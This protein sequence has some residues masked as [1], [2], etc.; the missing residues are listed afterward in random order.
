MTYQPV[1]RE[2]DIPV[3]PEFHVFHQKFKDA[4]SFFGTV[5]VKFQRIVH[6]EMRKG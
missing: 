6:I 4:R 2:D 3:H 1:E 5:G